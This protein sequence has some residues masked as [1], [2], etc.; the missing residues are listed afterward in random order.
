M[1][2]WMG[3]IGSFEIMESH[4]SSVWAH[5]CSSFTRTSSSRS[6]RINYQKY[7]A[8]QPTQLYLSLNP[9]SGASQTAAI[10]AMECCIEKTRKWMI[11]DKLMIN[12]SKTEF[13]LI[14]TLQQLCKLQPCVFSVG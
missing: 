4:R 12:D 14:G 6:L 10:N 13:I 8:T 9:R 7:T 5:C 11:R 2:L 1:W 3:E